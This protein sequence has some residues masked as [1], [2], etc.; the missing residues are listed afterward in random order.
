MIL[1]P[2]K[3][4]VYGS[5]G[6]QGTVKDRELPF[7]PLWDVVTSSSWMNHSCQK[8]NVHNIGEL[9]WF[10]QIVEPILLHQLSDNL[11]SYLR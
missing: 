5:T 4:F 9:S 10:F 2:T 6:G 1:L 7:Q 11:I 8:L 3:Y